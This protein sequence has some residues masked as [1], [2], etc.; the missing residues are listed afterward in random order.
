MRVD[1]PRGAF[2][3][4]SGPEGV[5]TTYC[6]SRPLAGAVAAQL[7]TVSPKSQLF[8]PGRSRR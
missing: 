2:K 8:L 6:G 1:A 4:T 3:K 5:P 7:G